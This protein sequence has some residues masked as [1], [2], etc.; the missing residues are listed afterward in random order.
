M[1]FEGYLTYLLLCLLVIGI[2]FRKDWR[3]AVLRLMLAAAF[4]VF[5][6]LLPPYL[7]GRSKQAGSAGGAEDDRF[8]LEQIE[9]KGEI[10]AQLYSSAHADKDKNTV[11]IEEALAV[12]DLG[13]RRRMMIDLLKQDS[14]Q[15]LD[16]L[17]LAVSNE[18]T[19]TS[20]Y[21]VSAIV[22]VKRKLTLA[23]Q[24]LSVRYESDKQDPHL[25]RSYADVL[26][27]YMSSGFLDDRTLLKHGY[28]YAEVLQHLLEADPTEPIHYKEKT[29]ADLAIKRYEQAEATAQSYLSRFPLNEEAYLLLVKVYYARRSHEQIVAV[30]KRLKAS[31]IRL[32]AQALALVRYWSED[33]YDGKQPQIEITS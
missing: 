26:K 5:G 20:H 18:D 16:V 8:R 3:E 23:M 15:Y 17:Q 22:E 1:W 14:I 11:P 30:L 7:T 12:N 10:L 29:E 13:T 25:L 19:E 9:K 21:A 2:K 32:S 28:T 33:S 4:P 27:A 6:L 24:E 31:P